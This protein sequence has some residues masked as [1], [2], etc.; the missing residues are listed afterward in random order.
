MEELSFGQRIVMYRTE[1]QMLQ[2][3]LAEK[4]GISPTVLNYYEKDKR[5]P[6]VMTIKRL[7]D[8]LS[9]TGDELLGLPEHTKPIGLSKTER[10]I[11]E[12]FR[13]L[14]EEGQ[15]KIVEYVDD[16]VSSQK[17]IKSYT[18]GMVDKEKNA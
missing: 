6:N 17:Y 13:S 4:V 1:K 3:E 10:R 2:K 18:D 7:A 16:L 11:V 9:I 15:E 14:N 8:V 12:G 5:E